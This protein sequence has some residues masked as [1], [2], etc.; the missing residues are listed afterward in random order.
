MPASSSV[1]LYRYSPATLDRETLQY[2]LVGR[3]KLAES[4]LEEIDQASGSG[5]PR[6]FLLVGPRGIGKSHLMT[7]LYQRI[8][9][10]L[11]ERIIPV[12][13]AEEEYSIFRASDFFLRILEEMGIGIADVIALKEDRLVRD[14]AVDTLKEIASTEG[15]LITIFVENLHEH[16]NQMD[17]HEIQA[18]RAIFQQTNAFSVVASAPSVFPGV[19]DHDEPFTISSGSF[20]SRNSNALKSKS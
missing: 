19:S 4:L 2:L 14:V 9:D 20:I 13:L 11:A 17:K 6:F 7:L 1:T 10:D 16:F 5:T 15:K 18:L 12:K 3:Q 8:R